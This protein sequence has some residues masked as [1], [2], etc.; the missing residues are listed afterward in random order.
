MGRGKHF[1]MD[2]RIQVHHWMLQYCFGIEYVQLTCKLTF[3]RCT[4]ADNKEYT[5]DG[6]NGK[7]VRYYISSAKHVHSK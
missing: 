2:P 7:Y 4:R 1:S 3:V 6:A 5:L